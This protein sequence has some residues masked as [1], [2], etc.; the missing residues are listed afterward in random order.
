[1]KEIKTKYILNKLES[2]IRNSNCIFFVGAAIS[3]VSPSLLP[4]GP[5]LKDFLLDCLFDKLKFRNQLKRIKNNVKYNSIVPEVLFQDIYTVLREKIFIIYKLLEKAKPNHIHNFLGDVLNNQT[6]KVYT[7]NFDSLIDDFANNRRI[8]KHLHGSLREKGRMAILI[9]QIIRGMN[10]AFKENF[11][12]DVKSKNLYFFGYS[13]ND[14]DVRDLINASQPAEIYWMMLDLKDS[15]TLNN[16]SLLKNTRIN[17]FQADMDT[18]FKQLEKRF[19]FKYKPS[20]NYTNAKLNYEANKLEQKTTIINLVNDYDRYK[21]L[22]LIYYRLQDYDYGYEVCKQVLKN[23]ILKNNSFET[24]LWFVIH[25]C[26]CIIVTK[27]NLTEGHRYLDEALKNKL[28][29]AYPQ[30]KGIINNLKGLY[31]I[32]C[33]APKPEKALPYLQ[34]SI[35][36]YKRALKTEKD[37]YQ[38]DDLKDCLSKTYNN[39]GYSNYLLNKFNLSFTY[40]SKSIKLKYKISDLFGLATTMVNISVAAFKIKNYK[41]YYYWKNQADALIEMYSLYFRK[42]Y[43]RKEIGILLFTNGEFKK[44]KEKLEEAIEI[45]QS[46]VPSATKE[47]AEVRKYLN[48]I[49]TSVH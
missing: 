25:I 30:E 41:K 3:M 6:I 32:D 8:I 38:I 40:F 15:R 39:I 7:T 24:R 26:D 1:M 19:K 44:A 33:K 49:D 45:L 9:R 29:D 20:I 35:S 31:Y 23:R 16:I 36:L 34:R 21:L 2:D 4:S 5:E 13:G 42:A 18:F 47:I 14:K 22:K 12:N 11:R 43:F 10:S 37:K 46:F 28:I 48:R 27:E 17:L